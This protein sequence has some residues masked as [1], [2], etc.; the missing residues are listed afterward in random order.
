MKPRKL[1]WRI[2]E[3]L[4][5]TV[6]EYDTPSDGFV[7]YDPDNTETR[8][9]L[10]TSSFISA[11]IELLQTE[12]DWE[13]LSYVLCHL[14][15]TLANKHLFCGPK[16]RIAIAKLLTMLCMDISRGDLASSIAVWP[17]GLKPRDAQG[18]AYHTLTVLISYKKCFEASQRHV[19]I[20][21]LITGLSAAQP[22]IKCCL[23]ALSLSAFEL[24]YSMR[25]FLPTILTKLSQ[26]M[27]NAAIAVHIIELLAI[28]GS[29]PLLTSNFIE[30]D[31]KMVFGVALQYLRLHNRPE[32]SPDGSWALSQH[33]RIMS[34]YIV[35]LWFLVVKLPDRP[36][37]VSFITRQL[38]LAN[39]GRSEPDEPAEVCFDW[40][41]RYTYGSADPRPASSMLNEVVTDPASLREREASEVVSEKTWISGNALVTVRALAN[42]GWVDVVVR[43][44]SGF[45]K[46]L[47]HI[48]N[49]PMVGPGEAD[50]DMIL[51]P[52]ILARNRE[53]TPEDTLYQVCFPPLS[54]A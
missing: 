53:P 20:E 6:P 30:A 24:P 23:H 36:R 8:V 43:R 48:E 21:V 2:P 17:A 44:A 19:L 51:V 52:A 7:S 34:Y 13:I 45:T 1:L 26:I 10:P 49:V 27:T 35:Y 33:V 12:Q 40:L 16:A 9:E 47:V 41:A 18:L 46:M 37:H 15:I 50:P 38:L 5:F 42:V 54:R 11:I 14:P 28:V 4:P 29:L 22:T 31:Y 32:T 39:E 25:R 3:V